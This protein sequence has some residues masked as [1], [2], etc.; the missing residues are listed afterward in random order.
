MKNSQL[1]KPQF[2]VGIILC[3]IAALMFLFVKADYSTAFVI[4]ILI[5]GLAAIATSRRK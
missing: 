3:V 5:L 2:V 4:T 1:N